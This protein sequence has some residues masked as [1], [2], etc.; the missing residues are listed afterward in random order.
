[1]LS[2]ALE[3]GFFDGIG[4]RE[5]SE[6]ERLR[7]KFKN[8]VLELKTRGYS[9]KT[10]DSYLYF[11]GRF[12]KFIEKEPRG[13]DSGDIKSYLNY[14]VMHNTEPR[15]MNLALQS[16]KCFY[17]S[18]LNKRLF[19]RIKRSK[20]PKDMPRVLSREEIAGMIEKTENPKHRLLIELLYSSGLRVGECVRLKIKD[21]DMNEKLIFI[22]SGKG[23]KDRYVILS[24]MFLRE[25]RCYLDKRKRTSD[26]LFEHN[27]GH[28]TERTA[29]EI[30]KEA[31]VRTGISHKVYPHLLRASFA[32][33]LIQKGTGIEKIQKIMGHSDVKTTQGYIRTTTDD[34]K[35]VKSPYDDM[36]H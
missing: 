20:I 35:K 36:I 34:I 2:K 16:L 9:E 25:M 26:Y 15:T 6:K 3:M 31:A 27:S 8:F 7:E 12:L 18:Y 19:S 30:V 10:I 14:M 5:P 32:T 17:E 1:M 21:I 22:K 4:K 33:H 28:I 11:N 24:E 23:K 29:E 13:I